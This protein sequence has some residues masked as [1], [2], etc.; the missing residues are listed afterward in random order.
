M[1]FGLFE[2]N[3]DMVLPTVN[4]RFGER[5]K[6]TVNVKLKEPKTADAL[7]VHLYGEQQQ[8]STEIRQGRA[9]DR[10]D[11]VRVFQTDLPLAGKQSYKDQSFPFEI[12]LPADPNPRTTLEAPKDLMGAMVLA[13]TQP[14]YAP[15]AAP[16]RW[17]VEAHMDLPMAFDIRKK[18]QINLG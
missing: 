2:G 4:Y 12:Q 1:V 5:L 13:M 16:I 9:V 14:R 3:V 6:G 7:M 8:K 10:Y 17:F 11:V 15:A 18:V